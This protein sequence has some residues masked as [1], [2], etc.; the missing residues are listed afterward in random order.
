M[1]ERLNTSGA[2]SEHVEQ[3]AGYRVPRTKFDAA[4]HALADIPYRL[5]RDGRRAAMLAVLDN[6]AT[7]G[8]IKHWR[9]G[10]RRPPQWAIDTLAKKIE[11]RVRA[12]DDSRQELVA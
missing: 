10:R 9:A 6:A 1:V 4:L 8:Q 2:R 7:W 11:R 3:F 12:L 5:S